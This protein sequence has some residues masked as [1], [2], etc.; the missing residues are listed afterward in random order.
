MGYLNIIQ[1]AHFSIC[2]IVL[3]VYIIFHFRQSYQF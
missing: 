3:G 2:Q 1:I